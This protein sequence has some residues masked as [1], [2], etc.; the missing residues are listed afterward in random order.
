MRFSGL[1]IWSESGSF[2][3]RHVFVLTPMA[4]LLVLPFVSDALVAVLID[5]ER[6]EGRLQPA[7]AIRQALRR[8]PAFLQLKLY[9][10]ARAVTWGLIPIYGLFRGVDERLAWAM[11]SNVAI[12]EARTDFSGSR[13]RCQ[14]LVSE[15]RG[16][17]IRALITIPCLLVL[18]IAFLLALVVSPWMFWLAVAGL[19]WLWLPGSS[20]A[21]TYLY[22]WIRG[23]ENEE[24]SHGTAVASS[25]NLRMEPSG[26]SGSAVR[27]R[28]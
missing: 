4:P 11:S 26:L 6:S 20:A 15:F 3:L 17:C 9:Y 13:A 21:N 1:R 2:F 24:S 10:Y 25:P 18:P 12:L 16:P 19:I 22:F 7:A 27:E 28:W 8:M 5:Q 23:N 14:A